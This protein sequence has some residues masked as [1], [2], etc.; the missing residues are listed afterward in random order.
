MNSLFQQLQQARPNLNQAQSPQLQK[1]SIQKNNLL[2]RFLSSSNPEQII[3]NMLATNPKLN[4]VMTMLNAS[5]MSPK[6][7]FYYYAQ[8]NGID[9]DQFINSMKE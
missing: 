8:Q 6:Q 3:Q 2:Q 9:P 7:F 4:N 5:N 1:S